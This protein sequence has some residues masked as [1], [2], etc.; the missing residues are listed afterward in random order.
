MSLMQH[1]PFFHD[2]NKLCWCVFKT[3]R[4]IVAILFCCAVYSS[5]SILEKDVFLGEFLLILP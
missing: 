3:K 1:F 4:F 5:G 2:V